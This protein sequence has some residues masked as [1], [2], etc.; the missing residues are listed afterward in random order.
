MFSCSP[1]LPSNVLCTNK[2][3]FTSLSKVEGTRAYSNSIKVTVGRKIKFPSE[4]SKTMVVLRDLGMG[5]KPRCLT[6][7]ASVLHQFGDDVNYVEKRI[8]ARHWQSVANQRHFLEWLAEQVS[9]KDIEGW[10]K[11]SAAE[12]KKRGGAG[13]LTH[14]GGS[15]SRALRTVFPEYKW[16][17]WKFSSVSIGEWE[18]IPN[19][20]SY[21]DWYAKEYEIKSPID[22]YKVSAADLYRRQGRGLLSVYDD[23]VV[24]AIQAVY[25]EYNQLEEVKNRQS[26]FFINRGKPLGHLPTCRGCK[27]EIPRQQL[28]IQVPGTFQPLNSEARPQVFNFHLNADCVEKAMKGDVKNFQ[29]SYPPYEGVV[30]VNQEIEADTQKPPGVT[31][32]TGHAPK[33]FADQPFC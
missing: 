6:T 29:V 14:Y 7:A 5:Q 19:Q 22:W 27:E 28:R 20:R 31:F 11:L 26:Y 30:W 21:M 2:S 8:P 3:F 25:P 33:L 32:K 17:F 16:Q 18:E 9:I 4:D 12:V 10:Y 23:S 1:R 15:L 24:K 13:L